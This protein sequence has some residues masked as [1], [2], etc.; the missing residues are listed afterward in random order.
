[1]N[2]QKIAR[3]DKCSC[4]SQKKYKQC[5]LNK[6]IED[7]FTT[8]NPNISEKCS[9]YIQY[10]ENQYPTCKVID[11]SNNLELSNYNNYQNKNLK[12]NTIMIA[13]KN[14]RTIQIFIKKKNYPLADIIIMYN[15]GYVLFE[16]KDFESAK[17]LIRRMM[18]GE[19]ICPNEQPKNK[20]KRK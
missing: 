13:E 1:M 5:C 3:N 17:E 11:I 2:Q 20:T 6:T 10:L 12:K 8:N 18:N 4:G 15:A 16:E 19:E 9:K 7:I 14:E